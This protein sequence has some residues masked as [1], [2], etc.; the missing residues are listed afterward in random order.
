MIFKIK[1]NSNVFILSP[2]ATNTGGVEL[3]HQLALQ[4]QKLNIKVKIVYIQ[5]QLSKHLIVRRYPEYNLPTSYFVDDFEDNYIIV[6]EIYIDYLKYFK[7]AKKIVWWLSVDNFYKNYFCNSAWGK[8]IVKVNNF[9]SKKN[10]NYLLDFD[11]FLIKFIQNYSK[12]ILHKHVSKDIINLTQSE[13]AKQHLINNNYY[14]IG[15][16]GDYINKKLIANLSSIVKENIVLYNPSKG[17][18]F[19]KKIIDA[20]KHIKFIALKDKSAIELAELYKIAKVYIDFGSHPGKDRIPR[21]AA[22]NNVVVLVGKR[23]AAS[24]QIDVP[25][26]IDYKF[27]LET[28]QISKIINKIEFVFQNYDKEIIR[29]EPYRVMIKNEE[30]LFYK[31]INDLFVVE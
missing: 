21:E 11:H 7:Y 28:E 9:L 2:S 6:P 22:I 23:G 15:Y 20:G 17:M 4:L 24:N 18:Y 27:E 10:I 1:Q 29:F 14:N 3:L 8:F 30:N 5:N 26:P 13:Y 31:Q 25:I 19:T 12:P 16:L